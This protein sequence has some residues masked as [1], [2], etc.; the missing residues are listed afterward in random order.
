MDYV[1]YHSQDVMGNALGKGPPF[2]ML[3]RKLVRH[4][5]GKVVWVIESRG[6]K[7]QYFLRQKFHVDSVT[8]IEK[9]YFRFHYTGNEGINFNP[10]ILLNP[11]P[12]FKDFLKAVANFSIGVS[13]LK[14]EFHHHF[15][16]LSGLASGDKNAPNKSDWQLIEGEIQTALRTYKTRSS[17]ART[18]CIEHH[19]STCHVCKID[20]GIVY[21]NDCQ[22]FIEVHHRNPMAGIDGPYS[23][24]PI[25][26]LVPL[27]PNCHRALHI[28]SVDIEA[29]AKIYR[30]MSGKS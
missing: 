29:L 19:G 16:Q 26:D 6:K 24:D 22:G 18:R 15:L 20:F 3:S 13:G 17:E 9:D 25:A 11:Y 21:G 8:E 7:K 10:E 23:I 27:C 12:W 5:A 14:P 1:A 28:L 30:K 2:G 4:L